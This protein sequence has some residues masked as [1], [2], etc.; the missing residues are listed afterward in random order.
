MLRPMLGICNRKTGYRGGRRRNETW[1]R[2]TADTKQ[3]SE[4]LEDIMAEARGIGKGQDQGPPPVGHRVDCRK[5]C[6]GL[7]KNI[8]ITFSDRD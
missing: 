8:Y 1:W 6:S 2:Q 3:L 5:G 4:R 7:N